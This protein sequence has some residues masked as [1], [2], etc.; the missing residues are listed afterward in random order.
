M[1]QKCENY[2]NITQGLKEMINSHLQKYDD[3][4]SKVSSKN[5][6]EKNLNSNSNNSEKQILNENNKEIV[7]F[8]NTLFNVD[9]EKKYEVEILGE[10][11]NRTKLWELIYSKIKL[12]YK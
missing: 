11:Y 1:W 4:K 2:R 5:T 3:T 8:L 10:K 12:Q 6:N 7:K 9:I